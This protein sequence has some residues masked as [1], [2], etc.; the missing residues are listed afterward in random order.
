MEEKE[1]VKENNL[2]TKV[3][4]G[5]FWTFGERIIAQ[6]V[7]FIVSIVLARILMPEEYGVVAIILVF[8]NIANVFVANGFGEAL[9]KKTD[10]DETD[11]STIFYCS[12]IFS[13]V[14]YFIL[15][16]S[17][18]PIAKFYGHEMLTPLLRVLA[19][20]IPISSVSTIQHAYV[21]KHMIFKKFFFSTLG[22]TIISGIVGI[23]M[24]STGCGPWA[25]VG[26]YLTNTIIDTL[27]LFVT[28]PWRPKW[29]FNISSAKSLISYGWKLTIS[30]LI[31]EVYGEMRSLIIGK[32]YSSA[33]LAFYNRGNQ[34]P[35]LIITNIDT[36]IGKVVFPA[37]TKVASKEE[38]LKQI[39]RRAM[40]TTSYVIFP[41]MVGL[42]F[43]GESLIDVLLGEKW[44]VCVPF[45]QCGCLYYMCQPIQTT[46]W[47]IIKAVGRSDLCL[48]LEIIKKII[49][50][51]IILG[52]MQFGVLAIAIGNAAFG[53]ISMIINII[54]NRKLINYSLCEQV[55]DI[56]PALIM[57]LVMG[58]IV[59]SINLLNFSKIGILFVQVIIGG[60]VYIIFSY[61]FKVESFMYLLDIVKNLGGKKHR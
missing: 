53:A 33:D 12:F 56:M 45:L 24:A 14:L 47:Q 5:L 19:L 21:S 58:I 27:V 7:S 60:G 49:G 40:K 10:S 59:Q 1:T 46:N 16:L 25:L 22:G 51:I 57:S 43:I 9:V 52:T 55:K 18:E 36:A 32:V 2:K 11:F 8:I 20:K 6:T 61:M 50:V 17:A 3:F 34:F 15:F 37:M 44:L 13:W 31:N 23:V 35:S 26:Q 38:R 39:S 30:S 28:V 4:S 29:I 54:P 42:M 48:K 41:M